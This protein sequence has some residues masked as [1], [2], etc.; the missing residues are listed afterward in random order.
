MRPYFFGE[1]PM[2]FGPYPITL[3]TVAVPVAGGPDGIPVMSDTHR[4]V[5]Y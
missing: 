3:D 5:R 4:K 2:R 1:Q